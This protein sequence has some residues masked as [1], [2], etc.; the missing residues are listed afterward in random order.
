MLEAT[1]KPLTDE[2]QLS[3]TV[4]MYMVEQVLQVMHSYGL[5]EE[6]ESVPW[7]ELMPT[8]Q[9]EWPQIALRGGRTKEGLTQKELS[10]RTGIPR[11]HLSAME[12]GKRPIGKKNA[13]KLAEA[14]N[15]DPRLFL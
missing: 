10:E 7:Q 2:V 14:L 6:N 13:A 4:P 15:L 5:R 3:F 11:S 12:N 9:E 1:R 8:K